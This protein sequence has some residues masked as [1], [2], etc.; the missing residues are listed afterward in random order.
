[1]KKIF[2]TFLLLCPISIIVA[3]NLKMG[4]YIAPSINSININDVE[5]E[6]NKLGFNYGYIVEYAFTETHSIESGFEISKH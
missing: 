5:K 3:Q 2:F 1:M 6:K 4:L